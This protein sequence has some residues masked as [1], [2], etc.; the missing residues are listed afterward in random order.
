[1]RA[2]HDATNS[3]VVKEVRLVALPPTGLGSRFLP[4]LLEIILVR[5]RLARSVASNSCQI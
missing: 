2:S 1:V 4:D 3:A 5:K